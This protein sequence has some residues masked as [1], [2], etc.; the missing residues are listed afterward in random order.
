MELTQPRYASAVPEKTA[1]RWERVSRE[2]FR[3]QR[4]E[5]TQAS[6]M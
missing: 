6:E 5:L 1:V 3:R 4:L 2:S